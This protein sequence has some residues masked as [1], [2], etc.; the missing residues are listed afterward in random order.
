MN[1]HLASFSV[2]LTLS[3]KVHKGLP[4]GT[5][6]H[7]SIETDKS[8]TRRSMSLPI[9]AFCDSMVTVC[10]LGDE[11]SG[12]FLDCLGSCRTPPGQKSSLTMYREHLQAS[13]QT[14][15]QKV[16]KDTWD[17]LWSSE[18]QK[19]LEKNMGEQNMSVRSKAKG[20][21]WKNPKHPRRMLINLSKKSSCAY[22]WNRGQYQ[23]LSQLILLHG[24]TYN[25]NKFLGPIWFCFRTVSYS[26]K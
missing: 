9:A 21:K 17:Q 7:S 18:M 26:K 8:W 19:Y 3:W 10:L 13:K 15:R 6:G 25:L 4:C 5:P 14:N 2:P 12:H 22:Y 1:S 11:P 24:D 16:Q 20:L 23:G